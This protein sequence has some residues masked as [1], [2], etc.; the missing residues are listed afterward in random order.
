[1][2]WIKD[3]LSH[4][5][6]TILSALFASISGFWIHLS[7]W[8]PEAIIAALTSLSSAIAG[9]IILWVDKSTLKAELDDSA[10]RA[11]HSGLYSSPLVV[12]PPSADPNT[13]RHH[14]SILFIDDEPFDIPQEISRRGF[15]VRYQ[16][17]ISNLDDI[18]H[19]AED[20]VFCDIAGVASQIFPE[21]EG[22]GVIRHL[23]ERVKVPP[24]VVA[25]TSTRPEVASEQSE[26]IYHIADARLKKNALEDSYIATA[27]KLLESHFS[28][29][30]FLRLS[31]ILGTPV[32]N[33]PTVG[34]ALSLWHQLRVQK[35]SFDSGSLARATRIITNILNSSLQ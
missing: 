14:C 10:K 30:Q 20:I 1:M 24:I 7:D 9:I 15:L 12:V 22:A 5:Y 6:V 16:Q 29:E 19:I 31:D 13:L 11:I 4:P 25:Y 32:L 33:P 18:D 27:M 17:F 26:I 21:I 34:C 28:L 2:N 8:E 35:A 23:K 3:F